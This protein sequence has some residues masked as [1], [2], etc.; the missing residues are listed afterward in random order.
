MPLNVDKKAQSESI[1]DLIA[2]LDAAPPSSASNNGEESNDSLKNSSSSNSNGR[3]MLKGKRTSNVSVCSGGGSNGCA[4]TT[5]TTTTGSGSTSSTFAKTNSFGANSEPILNKN[6]LMSKKYTKHMRSL[7]NRGLPKK[8]GAG[9]KHTWGAPGCELNSEDYLDANDPNYDSEDAGNVVMVCVENSDGGVTRSARR[10]A[11]NNADDDDESNALLKELDI[12]D[13]ECEIKPVLLEYFQNGDTIEVIDHLKCYNFSKLKPQL[14]AYS[15]SMALEH[16][17]TCKELMSRL[18]RDLHC[19]LFV[20]RDFVN[21]FDL[22]LRNLNDITLDNPDAAEKSGTFIARAIA[23]KVI[24]KKYIDRFFNDEENNANLPDLKNEKVF[25]A[26]E[27]ARL[28]VNMND[29]LYQLSHIWGNKGGF[30]AV[31]ELTDKINEL[32]QEYHDSGDMDEAIRCLKELNV[33][34]FHHEFIFEA[35]D[36]AL[37]KGNDHAINLITNLLNGLCKSVIV[38]YDQLKMVSF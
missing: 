21:G 34:H 6:I 28:L 9:G 30:L 37:Q 3:K 7:N 19:D 27:S 12:D 24:S 11:E 1:E 36:F 25:K 31:K 16:N 33:P 13:M 10:G 15:I 20:E 18:L 29:H 4:T 32:I 38:T 26:I 35:L 22:L 8:N 2:Q 17:N 23:D 14:I 5:A